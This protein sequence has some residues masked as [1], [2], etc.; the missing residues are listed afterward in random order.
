MSGHDTHGPGHETEDL[1][2]SSGLWVIPLSLAILVVFLFIAVVWSTSAA[3]NELLRNVTSGLDQGI[4][5]VK[6]LRAGDE[7]I[8]TSYGEGKDGKARIPVRRAME[9]LAGSDNEND[10]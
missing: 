3:S 9:I 2:F 1:D 8:L 5:A 6:A 7:A 10:R 4:E